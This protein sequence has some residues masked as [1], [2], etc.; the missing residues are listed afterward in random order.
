MKF[1]V[2]KL[3]IE[4]ETHLRRMAGRSEQMMERQTYKLT[5][6]HPLVQMCD[7]ATPLV[8]RDRLLF[9]WFSA[10]Y[11]GRFKCVTSPLL[12]LLSFF[13]HIFIYHST[14]IQSSI[15]CLG[16]RFDLFPNTFSSIT[17]Y[18]S[19]SPLR[20][21]P[22]NFFC[23]DFFIVRM[24]DISSPI[25]SNTSSFVLCTVQLTFSILL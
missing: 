25:V 14:I 22:I 1:R 2:D 7:V 3:D 8:Y 10:Y 24:R 13:F 18:N 11:I 12:S 4:N 9:F 17:V 6:I 20:V 16:L 5:D 19:D 21:C 23:L 15:I